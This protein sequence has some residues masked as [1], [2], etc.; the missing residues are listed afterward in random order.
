M[1][2]EG[3]ASSSWICLPYRD[4]RRF[5]HDGSNAGKIPKMLWKMLQEVGYEK[6]PKYF[7]TQV[8]YEGSESVWHVQVYIF[9]PS[10]VKEFL[11]SRRSMPPSP[12]DASSMAPVKLTWS[13]VHVMANSCME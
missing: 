4:V 3:E 13:L 11:K 6:Q 9:T 5:L 2:Q 1:E 7:G 8:M 10:P 12:Q